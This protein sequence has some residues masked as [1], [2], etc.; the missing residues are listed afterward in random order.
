M[1]KTTEG[2]AVKYSRESR[3]IEV[4]SYLQDY[5]MTVVDDVDTITDCD[6]CGQEFDLE[7]EG[8]VEEDEAF[9]EPCYNRIFGG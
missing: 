8:G 5:T 1:S 9:C 4:A 2:I 3:P 6:E 7:D